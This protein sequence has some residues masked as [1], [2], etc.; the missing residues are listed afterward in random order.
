M[1]YL[2]RDV[3]LKR[4]HDFKRKVWRSQKTS[5]AFPHHQER[6]AAASITSR[7]KHAE[8]TDLFFP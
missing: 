5:E 4:D 1:C 2:K 8:E 7:I 6:A 3:L